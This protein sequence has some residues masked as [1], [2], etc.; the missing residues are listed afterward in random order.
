MIIGNGLLAKNFSHYKKN[1]NVLFFVSG[2]SNSTE[3]NDKEFSKEEKL[4]RDSIYKIDKVLFI[5]FSSCYVDNVNMF[6]TKYYNHKKAMENIIKDNVSNYIIFRL[7]QVV[8]DGGNNNNL[9][10]FLFK[11]IENGN[12]F[13]LFK[14]AT[15][16]LIDVIDVVKTVDFIIVNN[17][18]INKVIN[19]ASPKNV[20]IV[21]VVKKIETIV[22]RKAQYIEENKGE[23]IE[24]DISNINYIFNN[25]KIKFNDN[26]VS[27]L[28][29]KYYKI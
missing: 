2:V 13:K 8:G 1:S 22:K 6:E 4:L 28:L 19:I 24:I 27:N 25:L 7:P 21:H 14:H 18:F 15:R 12:E 16:N 20:S 9:I 17:I 3:V 26:Y 5:Y 23:N 29:N 11:S 10:N